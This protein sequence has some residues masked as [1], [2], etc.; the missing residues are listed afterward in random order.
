MLRETVTPSE[1]KD[2]I[3]NRGDRTI[4]SPSEPCFGHILRCFV[5]FLL[6]CVKRW[7][8][9]AFYL[10]SFYHIARTLQDGRVKCLQPGKEVLRENVIH[11]ITSTMKP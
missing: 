4:A 9:L 5:S 11:I 2:T 1:T 3:V 10:K 7:L 8:P 6:K